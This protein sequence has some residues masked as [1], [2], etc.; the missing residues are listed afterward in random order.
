M[1]TTTQKTNK[2][3]TPHRVKRT[4]YTALTIYKD[5][6]K[7][8]GD[9]DTANLSW[10]TRGEYPR[11][12]VYTSK[13]CK[14]AN[15]KID[16][17]KIIIAPM[18]IITLK[19][20]LSRAIKILSKGEK[21]SFSEAYC[22]NNRYKDGERTNEKY[23]QAT[24][25]IGIDKDGKAYIAAYEKSKPKIKFEFVTP[26]FYY[27]L[28]SSDEEETTDITLTPK[29]TRERAAEYLSIVRDLMN[30]EMKLLKSV[31]YEEIVNGVKVYNRVETEKHK[32]IISDED[33]KLLDE[34]I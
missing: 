2:I 3:E 33:A 30:D 31:V 25:R 16:W 29:Q 13:N 24:M 27:Q 17:S 14:D 20:F 11:I 21:D 34:L 7:E 1:A 19:T 8:N 9:T 5:I 12:T 18:D 26:D 32:D 28:R 22:Y 4:K 10:S 15:S 6:A 23:L